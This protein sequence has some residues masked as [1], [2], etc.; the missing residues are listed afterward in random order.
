MP[1]TAAETPARIV[2]TRV[3]GGLTVTISAGPA[4]KVTPEAILSPLDEE[5]T[6]AYLRYWDV[7]MRAYYDADP[8]IL[9]QMMAGA[10]LARETE[11]VEALRAQGRAVSIDVEQNFRILRAD[12]DEA[13]V[14]DEYV[15]RSRV[16]DGATKRQLGAGETQ[17]VEKIS[18]EFRRL[19]GVWKVVDGARH[20]QGGGQAPGGPPH[21]TDQGRPEGGG[22]GA[23]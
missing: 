5:V 23:E 8:S 19:G 2:V 21:A 22:W 17:E 12:E 9:P 13:V 4:W 16:V 3:V 18:Y 11:Q 1:T 15:N 20:D 6:A 7:R 14:Y 10:E